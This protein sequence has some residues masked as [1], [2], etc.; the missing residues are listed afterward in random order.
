[1][2]LISQQ[3]NALLN[4]SAQISCLIGQSSSTYSRHQT[5]LDIGTHLQCIPGAGLVHTA[6]STLFYLPCQSALSPSLRLNTVR[7]KAT[8]H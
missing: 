2:Q 7:F 4:T 1:M 6:T 3:D 8:P 5:L